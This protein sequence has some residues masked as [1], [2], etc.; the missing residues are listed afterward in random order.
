MWECT[1]CKG[2]AHLLHPH[3]EMSVETAKTFFRLFLFG[4][5]PSTFLAEG[6]VLGYVRILLLINLIGLVQMLPVS[7]CQRADRTYV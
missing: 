1:I 3:W 6:T 4:P 2:G 7:C 5:L